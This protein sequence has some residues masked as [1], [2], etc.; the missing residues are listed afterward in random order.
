M[1][2]Y[3]PYFRYIKDM[4]I[5]IILVF[6]FIICI[7]TALPIIGVVQSKEY[8]N[9][10]IN[11]VSQ[12]SVSGGIVCLLAGF[13]YSL[14][15]FASSMNIRADRVG[16]LKAVLLWGII[17]SVGFALFSFVFDIL[18][19]LILEAWTGMPTNVYSQ[20][21][22]IDMRNLQLNTDII[23]RIIGNMTIFSLG[24]LVGAMWYRLKIRTSI[25]LFVIIPIAFVGY[26]VNFGVR[27]PEKMNMLIN[28]I[29]NIA[30]QLIK[31]TVLINTIMSFSIVAFSICGIM[32]LIKA[33]I[34]DY[35]ND[36]L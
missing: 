19:K 1:S 32:L 27:N 30:E 5:K 33:P 36:L 23:S 14:A 7:N 10:V 2:N 25:V 26:M 9:D 11:F 31:N 20:M 13:L 34:K 6:A 12:C 16:Y 24:F 28:N 35:A 8:Q 21:K 17:L 22:W 18:C 3:K 4:N 29:C 15:V